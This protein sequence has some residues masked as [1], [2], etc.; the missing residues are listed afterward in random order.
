MAV[1]IGHRFTKNMI[2]AGLTVICLALTTGIVSQRQRV[3]AL[4]IQVNAT[5]VKALY[6]AGELISGIERDLQK[7]MVSANPTRLQI[8]LTGIARQA[9]S[10]QDNLAVIPP[11]VANLEG[12]IKF[13]NQAG[14]FARCAGEQLAL[15]KALTQ[16]DV[17]QIHTLHVCA[18]TLSTTLGELIDAVERGE[19]VFPVNRQIPA[20]R[21]G[22]DE[23]IQ[24][25]VDYP[26]LL[27]DG[28]FSDG[29]DA[30]VI[31]ISGQLLP[32]NGVQKRLIQ[33]IGQDRVSDIA[34][35]GASDSFA[36]CYEYAV[37]T[38]SGLLYAAVTQ[39][40]AH[41]LYM[42]PENPPSGNG[43]TINDCIEKGLDFLLTR[44]FGQMAVSYFNA[45]DGVLTVNYAAVEDDV[46]LYPDLVKVQISMQN[47]QVIGIESANYLRNHRQRNLPDPVFNEEMAMDKLHPGLI[48]EDIRR[49]VIPL[50]I[51]EA[52]CWEITAHINDGGRFLIYIDTQTGQ[53]QTIL[54]LVQEGGGAV[55]Q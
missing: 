41:V 34:Y 52:Q 11:D 35:L 12:A 55:T 3:H 21:D 45:Q 7:L 5:Y 40:G 15:G 23:T 24:P 31:S 25:P 54:Q 49:C 44:G 51:S 37:E 18:Q 33:F 1:Q 30:G 13:V 36:P 32:W 10:A 39:I 29:R 2:I 26:E 38:E 46:I 16:A 27:Y 9:E 47:G 19:L 4:S 28:P 8:L 17:E 6:E 43:M 42:L 53:E 22:D 20:T 50:E 14:D 48:V